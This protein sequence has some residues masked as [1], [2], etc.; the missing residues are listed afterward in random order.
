LSSFAAGSGGVPVEPRHRPLRELGLP[1][2]LGA[3]VLFFSAM[4]LLSANI[5][6]MRGNMVWIKHTQQVL[7][8]LS[9]LEAALG[10]EELTVR[11][12]ALTGDPR[13]LLYQQQERGRALK[14]VAELGRLAEAEAPH[15]ERARRLREAVTRHTALLDSLS[16]APARVVAA[17]IVD[18]GKRAV[19]KTPRLELAAFRAD[20]VRTLTGRQNQLTGQLSHAFVLAVGII[21]AAFLLGGLGLLASQFHLPARGKTGNG[22][23]KRQATAPGSLLQDYK[24]GI[25]RELGMPALFGACVLL[26][27]ATLLLGANI[28]AMRGNLAWIGRTQQILLALADAETGVVGDQLTLRGYALTGDARF[29]QYQKIERD[30]L[31]RALERLAQLTSPDPGGADRIAT[32]RNLIRQHRDNYDGVSGLGPDHA[33]AVAKAIDDD[34]KRVIMFR[35][36]GALAAFRADEVRALGERQDHLT[37]QLGQS[38]L[39]A[40]GIIVAAFLLGGLGLIASQLRLPSWRAVSKAG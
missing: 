21:V 26:L 31:R 27:S 18:P 16:G 32:V 15:G 5:S 14:A 13:F 11:S 33:D 37:R 8:Q 12:Y 1:A 4:L 38:F 28:E 35:L 40:V 25:L 9:A 20:E 17:A 36:R 22:Q 23:T 30:K 3:A 7:H 39:L 6:A 2:L 29:L 10:G 34:K 24:R 19:V